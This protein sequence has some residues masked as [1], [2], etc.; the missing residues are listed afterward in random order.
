M[1]HPKLP[2]L[3]LSSFT[4]LAALALATTGCERSSRADA[5]AAAGALAAHELSRLPKE[6]VN[7]AFADFGGKLHLVGY[8]LEPNDSV[9]PGGK[10]TL[11]LYWRSVAPLSPGFRLTT[12]L[13]A[14]RRV[15]TFETGGP[16]RDDGNLGPSAWTPG[17]IYV[18]EQTLSIPSDL[19]SR[20]ITIAVSVTRDALTPNADGADAAED[21]TVTLPP[22]RLPVLSGPN[23][24]QARAIVAHVKNDVANPAPR[25]RRSA[26]EPTRRA[27]RAA[28]SAR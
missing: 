20:E 26:A 3:V 25:A 28:T 18:D 17:K 22:V 16:L 27:P 12:Y 1:K 14:G 9:R 24:G 5:Q 23:D 13:I 8:A 7:H 19:R 2:P 15:E 21:D 11:R 6:G 4:A 10:L